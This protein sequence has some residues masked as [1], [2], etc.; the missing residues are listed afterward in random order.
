MNCEKVYEVH[1]KTFLKYFLSAGS[2]SESIAIVD[3]NQKG[4]AFLSSFKVLAEEGY[5]K[6]AGY[7]DRKRKRRQRTLTEMT[8]QKMDRGVGM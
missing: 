4:R 3:K 7:S 8:D 2:L 5:L 6:V 1:C